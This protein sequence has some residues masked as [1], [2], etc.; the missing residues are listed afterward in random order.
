MKK[1]ITKKSPISTI[2]T[3]QKPYSKTNLIL[4]LDDIFQNKRKLFQNWNERWIFIQ[5]PVVAKL[6]FTLPFD[7]KFVVYIDSTWKVLSTL[8]L[9][10]WI[11]MDIRI[12]EIRIFSH[13]DIRSFALGNDIF[14]KSLKELKFDWYVEELQDFSSDFDNIPFDLK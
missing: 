3:I 9:E 6:I 7:N 11:N 5:Y 1:T 4:V 12:I 10:K 14:L 2:Y 8:I 13:K